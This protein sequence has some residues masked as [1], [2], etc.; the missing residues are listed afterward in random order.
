MA[1]QLAGLS[2]FSIIGLY[3]NRERIYFHPTLQLEATPSDVRVTYNNFRIS[4]ERAVIHGWFIKGKSD[5]KLIIFAHGNAG[6]ISHRL[7]FIEFW[8]KYLSDYSLV[9]FDYPGFGKS[10]NNKGSFS[11]TP[12]V[13][14]AQESVLAILEKFE[15]DGYSPKNT[16]IIGES[17]G[18]A[19]VPTAL[20]KRKTIY[21]KIVL[22]STFSKLNDMAVHFIPSFR[23]FINIIPDDLNTLDAVKKLISRGQ[24]V[25]AMHS[26]TDEI[27][28]FSLFE[29]LKKY[30]TSSLEI[31]GGHN[32]PVMNGDVADFIAF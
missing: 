22:F 16:I 4:T 15:K 25:A 29:K 3:L 10:L 13:K 14:S 17:I 2:G 24:N 19:I 32:S 20:V 23:F 21:K 26:R 7:Y 30:V 8:K 12:A 11:G 28:P 27:I 31:E 5:D 18:G 1:F 6:N 9:L